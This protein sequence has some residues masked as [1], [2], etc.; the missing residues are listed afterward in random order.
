M[1]TKYSSQITGKKM[2]K[3]YVFGRLK[4]ELPL[5]SLY[6]ISSGSQ[7]HIAIDPVVISDPVVY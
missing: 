3:G 1:N 6:P 5:F 2:Q 7:I 4:D